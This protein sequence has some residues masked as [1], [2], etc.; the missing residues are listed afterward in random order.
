LRLTGSSWP[1]SNRSKR[2]S[3]RSRSTAPLTDYKEAAK[4]LRDLV[5]DAS[6]FSA[7][8]GSHGKIAVFRGLDIHFRN[9]FDGGTLY[10]TPKGVEFKRHTTD[11][12]TLGN[13]PDVLKSPL[14]VIGRALGLQ[15]ATLTRYENRV[16][17][18]EREI[19]AL[20]RQVGGFARQ[21]ELNEA[22]SRQAAINEQLAQM[23]IGEGATSFV[24]AEKEWEQF[25]ATHALPE[26]ELP[27][28]HAMGMR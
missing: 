21:D 23:D 12:M 2:A 25:V 13:G 16:E 5:Q 8:R 17:A 14:A 24:G 28:V 22:Y 27:R 19:E 7:Y 3:S 6:T 1:T 10:A 18:T 11:F 20:T 15:K 9:S 26:P 4:A